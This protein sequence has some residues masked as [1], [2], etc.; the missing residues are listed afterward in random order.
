MREQHLDQGAGAGGVAALAA[1][2]VPV[3][4]M[5][6]GEGAGRARLGQRGGAGQRAGLAPQDLQVVVQDQDLGVLAGRALVPGHDL[7][8]VEHLHGR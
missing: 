2:G 4:L 1:G 6:G 3:S 8:P 5:G 7:R